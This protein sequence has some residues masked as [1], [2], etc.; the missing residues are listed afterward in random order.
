MI[1]ENEMTDALNKEIGGSHYKRFKYQPIEFIMKYKL[2]F[3]EGNIFKYLCRYKFKD[4]VK[5]LEKAMHYCELWDKFTGYRDP[6]SDASVYDI[7]VFIS[8][9]GLCEQDG[10]NGSASEIGCLLTKF[11]AAIR[12]DNP[13]DSYSMRDFVEYLN[14]V[15]RYNKGEIDG[16]DM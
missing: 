13:L 6:T 5:D 8:K 7:L 4:G 10:S 15:I 14:T 16:Y 11:W 3:I 9:N 12:R 1:K 2:N